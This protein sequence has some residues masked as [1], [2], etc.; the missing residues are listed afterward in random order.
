MSGIEKRKVPIFSPLPS[1][2]PEEYGL[3]GTSRQA[4]GVLKKQNYITNHGII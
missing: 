2:L 3:E 1:P 4:G